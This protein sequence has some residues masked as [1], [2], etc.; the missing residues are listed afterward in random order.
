MPLFGLSPDDRQRI[1]KAVESGVVA[2]DRLQHHEVRCTE[3]YNDL[4]K[5]IEAMAK[6]RADDVKQRRAAMNRIFWL[7]LASGLG[8]VSLIAKELIIHGW[9]GV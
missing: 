1:D 5:T 8:I 7:V 3:R 4:T 2:L 9:P 6:L